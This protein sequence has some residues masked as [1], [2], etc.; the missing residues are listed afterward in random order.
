[1]EVEVVHE[2]QQPEPEPNIPAAKCQDYMLPQK[3]RASCGLAE[4]YARCRAFDQICFQLPTGSHLAGNVLL[5]ASTTIER[6]FN[7]H[8]PMIFK[9]GWT[10]DPAFRWANS[11]FGYYHDP[12]VRWDAMVVLYV[13]MN[14]HGP[15]MFEAALID[16]YQSA[17]SQF[18]QSI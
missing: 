5:H 9:I 14:P 6:L 17:L 7:D 16:K 12:Y 8:G 13:A 10:H 1:M 2:Q 18:C 4:V 15:A 11:L 3:E